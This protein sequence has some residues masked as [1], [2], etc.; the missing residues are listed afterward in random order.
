MF[1]LSRMVK[2][3]QTPAEI[4]L[5]KNRKKIL[6]KTT[7]NLALDNYKSGL[8]TPAKNFPLKAQKF[9]IF[10]FFQEA[11]KTAV[12]RRRNRFLE[13]TYFCEVISLI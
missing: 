6:E 11:L 12:Q 4:F 7:Q 9:L 2:R 13:Q 1:K 10:G 3:F 8:T 5:L